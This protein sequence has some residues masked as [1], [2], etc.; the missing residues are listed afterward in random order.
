M[1]VQED[2]Y[3]QLLW[4]LQLSRLV[5]LLVDLAEHDLLELVVDCERQQCIRR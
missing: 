5:R 1:G 3:G 2:G 4:E